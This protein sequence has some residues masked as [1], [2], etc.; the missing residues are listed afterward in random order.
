[1]TKYIPQLAGAIVTLFLAI[2]GAY[3]AVDRHVVALAA[4]SLTTTQVE[5]IIDLKTVDKLDEII[6]RLQHIDT[7][8]DRLQN[9]VPRTNVAVSQEK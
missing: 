9:T 5:H 3:L 6:R 1:M 7:Q 4:T 2:V 8:I